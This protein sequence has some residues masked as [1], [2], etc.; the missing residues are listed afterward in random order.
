MINKCC[1]YIKYYRKENSG[2]GVQLSTTLPDPTE[3][4]SLRRG[5]QKSALLN[6]NVKKLL[7]HTLSDREPP[8]LTFTLF[9]GK[10][11]TINKMLTVMAAST[12]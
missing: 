12:Y 8:P 1:F 2:F 10:H 11:K 6:K 3:L 7:S 5:S 9:C 4:E